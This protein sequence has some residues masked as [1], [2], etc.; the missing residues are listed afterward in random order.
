MW[1]YFSRHFWDFDLEAVLDIS[2]NLVVIPFSPEKVDGHASGIEASCP[3]H[4]MQVGVSVGREVKVYDQV[5]PLNIDPPAEEVSGNK[6]SGGVGLEEV[7]ALDS[8]FLPKGW[9]DADGVEQLEFEKVSEALSPFHP[10]CKD[11]NLI[12]G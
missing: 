4:S 10:I 7:V 11:D 9:V 1:I 12:K 6:Q 2:Q 5:Y 3:P 8:L